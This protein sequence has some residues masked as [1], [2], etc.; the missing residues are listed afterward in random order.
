MMRLPPMKNHPDYALSH[1]DSR[2]G[3]DYLVKRMTLMIWRGWR[4]GMK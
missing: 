3:F 2:E 4:M 1:L